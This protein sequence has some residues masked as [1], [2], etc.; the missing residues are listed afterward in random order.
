MPTGAKVRFDVRA[1]YDAHK[2]R[3][4][5]APPLARS[6]AADNGAGT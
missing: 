1:C 3:G 6:P 5:G 4:V 2:L